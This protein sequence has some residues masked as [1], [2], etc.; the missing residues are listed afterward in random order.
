MR[1]IKVLCLIAGLSITIVAVV[2]LLN[3]T[4][5]NPTGKRYSSQSHFISGSS[6]AIGLSGERILAHES[7]GTKG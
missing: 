7:D 1:R 2:L 4:A 5:P 3:L 6:R